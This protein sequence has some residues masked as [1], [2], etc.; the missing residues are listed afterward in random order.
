M[1]LTFRRATHGDAALLREL[2][3]ALGGEPPSLH[4]YEKTLAAIIQNPCMTV[5]LALSDARVVG[6]YTLAILPTLGL[7][8]RPEAIV[9]S[10]II[11]P[12]EQGHGF[13]RAMMHHAM[14]L[15]AEAGCYKL[16]LSSNFNHEAAHRF[17]DS[18]GFRRHGVSFH[19]DLADDAS[20]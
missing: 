14:R 6:T 18:L 1:Q 4:D 10:V 5:W 9:E 13:G 2:A 19:V 11:A 7:R 3:P 12:A 20:T 15:A 16:M 17:Y 8:C